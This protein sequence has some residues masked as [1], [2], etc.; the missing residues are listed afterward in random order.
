LAIFCVALLGLAMADKTAAAS[1][2]VQRVAMLSGK[3]AGLPPLP[4]KKKL[5]AQ[6][7]LIGM[8]D[9]AALRHGLEPELVHAVILAESRY[10]P[11]A[12]SHKGAMGL[13]Q[14]MPETAA[15]YGVRDAWSPDNNIDGGVRYLRDL[16]R[17]F[18][19]IELA[20]AAY[21]AG[22]KAVERYGNR[23]PPYAETEVYVERVRAYLEKL[24]K[25]S[26]VTKLIKVGV[27]GVGGAPRLSGWGVIFGSYLDKGEA[28][29]VLKSR[30]SS[31]RGVVRTGR[32]AVV[33][34]DREGG[35]RFAALL[36]GLE[37]DDASAACKRIRSDG[38]YCLALPP[39]QLKDPSALWR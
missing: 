17:Q 14:L 2:K 10:N 28:R 13:M 3:I 30:R 35:Y 8:A 32:P 4:K 15:R 21:N 7:A 11:K 38:D 26:S 12:L 39:K 9:G 19:D 6:D 16:I 1:D 24:N 29:E 36:V 34:R 31:L 33:E 22:E 5:S 20:V 25:G 37:Q 23:V 27:P 18:G